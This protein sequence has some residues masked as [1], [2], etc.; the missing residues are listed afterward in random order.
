VYEKIKAEEHG[1]NVGNEERPGAEILANYG[2]EK[3][4]EWTWGSEQSD[5]DDDSGDAEREQE[6]L[7][8]HK[9][10]VTDEPEHGERG[11]PHEIN[12]ERVISSETNRPESVIKVQET[13]WE[14]CV[15][16]KTIK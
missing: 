10:I 7:R 13:D 3:T 15:R 1:E 5:L 14:L 4:C 12:S 9:W 16:H 8:L 11:I 2:D 6:S